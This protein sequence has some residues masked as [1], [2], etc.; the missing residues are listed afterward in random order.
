MYIKIQMQLETGIVN[1][2][3]VLKVQHKISEL[4]FFKNL[5]FTFTWFNNLGR[6]FRECCPVPSFD[7]KFGYIVDVS[8]SLSDFSHWIPRFIQQEIY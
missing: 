6:D 5:I 4:L 8:K 3:Y 7:K 2:F 1:E